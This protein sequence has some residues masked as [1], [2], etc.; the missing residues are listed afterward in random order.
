[1]HAA[2]KFAS[3]FELR[4][5][6]QEEVKALTEHEEFQKFI[7]IKEREEEKK[8][9]KMTFKDY[10]HIVSRLGLIEVTMII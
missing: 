1:M 9:K 6:E 2:I 3:Y 8:D 5:L 10:E 4:H 7:E